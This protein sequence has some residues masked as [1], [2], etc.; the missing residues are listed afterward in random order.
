MENTNY[1]GCQ[2]ESPSD[3]SG[4]GREH[5]GWPWR[6]CLHA[7]TDWWPWIEGTDVPRLSFQ[8]TVSRTCAGSYWVSGDPNSCFYHWWTK[9]H[10]AEGWEPGGRVL[11]A[12]PLPPT[13]SR[14]TWTRR[15]GCTPS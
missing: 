4:E 11:A 2:G 8:H 14:W 3:M 7:A 13:G 5:T 9:V 12:V 1:F 15:V 10:K 6:K